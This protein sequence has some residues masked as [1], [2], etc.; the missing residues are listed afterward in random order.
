MRG[1]QF[2]LRTYQ[3]PLLLFLLFVLLTGWMLVSL[4]TSCLKR[5]SNYHVNT[6]AFC[7]LFSPG[8]LY[9]LERG[10]ILL[11][12]IPLTLFFVMYRNSENKLLQELALIALALAAGMK[13]Y[14]AFF[15][16]LLIRDKKYAQ[17]IRAIAYGVLSVILP[18]LFFNEGLAGIPMWLSVVFNFGGSAHSPWGG[19]SFADILHRLASYANRSWGIAVDSSLFAP[20]SAVGCGILLIASLGYKKEWQS[21]LSITVAVIAFQSQASYIFGFMCIPLLLFLAQEKK[22]ESGN[23]LPFLLML[24]LTVHL[25]LFNKRTDITIKQLI[26]LLLTCWCVITAAAACIRARCSLSG[27]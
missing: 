24:L 18:V 4:C 7:M 11:L 9:A 19:V 22:L 6:V 14:P 3:A 15:G 10:N 5:D 2:D 27:R 17:A 16:V 26:L 21:I 12:V 25:P 8:I 20:V 13:L 1:T 23:I